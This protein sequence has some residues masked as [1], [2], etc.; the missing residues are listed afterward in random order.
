MSDA[1]DAIAFFHAQNA[2]IEV[3]A[4]PPPRSPLGWMVAA[5]VL[6]VGVAL[7]LAERN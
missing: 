4:R 2:G 5:V 1:D 7:W 6:A 3:D